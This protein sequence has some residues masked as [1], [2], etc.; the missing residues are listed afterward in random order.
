[1]TLERC[2]EVQKAIQTLLR[3]GKQ[4]PSKIT[5]K[6]TRQYIRFFMGQKEVDK[7]SNLYGGC[8]EYT[9]EVLIKGCLVPWLIESLKEDRSK[10]RKVTAEE[11]RLGRLIVLHE[12]VLEAYW[13]K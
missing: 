2:Q 7:I 3:K 9:D 1:M 13:E 4:V 12:K 8:P 10:F 6:R 11:K 5:V